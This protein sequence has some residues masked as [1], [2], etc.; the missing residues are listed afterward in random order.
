MANNLL[1]LTHVI[2]YYLFKMTEAVLS[3][4]ENLLIIIMDLQELTLVDME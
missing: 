2:F 3:Y 1:N 4:V